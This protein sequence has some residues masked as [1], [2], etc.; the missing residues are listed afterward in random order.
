[1]DLESITVVKLLVD[2]GLVIL[3]LMVQLIVYPSFLY[4][5][6]GRLLDWHI[7]YTRAIT[8]IVAPLMC[9]QLFIALYIAF[10]I[11]TTSYTLL[12]LAL[13]LITWI[14]TMLLF[15]P[16]HKRINTN[17]F[18]EIDLQKLVS[19]NWWRVLVWVIIFVMSI[20][21]VAYEY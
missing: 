14:L 6:R 3:I 15:V 18:T 19:R 11:H 2:F 4:L 10:W 20:L 5:E 13:V 16:I 8:V 12:N 1:M 9:L 21:R 17:T 7:K